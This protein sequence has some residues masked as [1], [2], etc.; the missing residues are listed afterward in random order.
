MPIE[1]TEAGRGLRFS[2]HRWNQQYNRKQIIIIIMVLSF[3]VSLL[4]NLDCLAMIGLGLIHLYSQ[5]SLCKL[6]T[7]EKYQK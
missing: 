5:Y 6:G 7:T 1:I 3:L 2:F 4:L